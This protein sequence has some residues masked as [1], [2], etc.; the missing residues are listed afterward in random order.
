[1]NFPRKWVT[2]TAHRN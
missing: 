2:V 1:M